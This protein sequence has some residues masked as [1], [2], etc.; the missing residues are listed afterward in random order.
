MTSPANVLAFPTQVV[1][2]EV[3]GEPTFSA[4]EVCARAGITYR[5]LDYWV[6]CGYVD[7]DD[8][9]ETH[10]RPGSGYQRRFTAGDI[11][12]FA[13]LGRLVRAGLTLHAA[14]DITRQVEKETGAPVLLGNGILLMVADDATEPAGD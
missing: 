4:P 6:R 14:V 1:E 9:D 2:P 7:L 12:R 5:N 8:T 3:E 10:R 13:T 11:N